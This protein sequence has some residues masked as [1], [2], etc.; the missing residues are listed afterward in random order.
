[1]DKIKWVETNIGAVYK[2]KSIILATGTYLRGK[3]FIGEIQKKVDQ[4]VFSSCKVIRMLKKLGIT[5]I[6]FKTGTP[7]RVNKN[8]IDFS[9]MELQEGDKNIEA[10]SFE[11]KIIK[12]LRTIT[13]LFDIY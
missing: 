8:S 12:T 9:K 11:D 6:R 3:V 1:M 5:L 10:F 7:A 4:M 2:V 13:L